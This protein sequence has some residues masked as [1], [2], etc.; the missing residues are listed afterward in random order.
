M[1]GTL[2]SIPLAQNVDENGLPL[3][4]CRLFLYLANTS[5]PVIAYKDYLLSA[6]MEHP[7]PI[8]ADALGRIP[9]FWLPTEPNS[10]YRAMLQDRYGT[11]IYDEPYMAALSTATG[12]GG[13]GEVVENPAWQTGDF[14]W[15]AV[16]GG[17]TGWV[18]ANGLTIGNALSGAVQR[19]NNDCAALF[20]TLW[21]RY[22]QEICPVL[23]GRGADAAADWGEEGAPG[24][25]IATYDM[26]AMGIRGVDGMGNS[27]TTRFNYTL[28]HHGVSTVPG[29]VVG[30]NGVILQWDHMPQH[31]HLAT[32]TNTLA[33]SPAAHQHG[34]TGGTYVSS[35]GS[36]SL[37]YDWSP[38]PLATTAATLELVGSVTVSN[39][40]AGANL[41]HD[42]VP[43]DA[44]GTW[45]IRL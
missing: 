10:F 24:K 16:S 36:G 6:G 19:A 32:V 1:T 15:Q 41:T 28:L 35:G 8:V 30:Q 44:L 13:G 21:N 43:L 18:I 2:P 20:T 29:A 22:P 40:T 33:I 38:T 17:R 26:R 12:G 14:M 9:M 23:G 4:G 45:Y 11:T 42:N 31:G 37:Q 5:T 7:H 27:A 34:Y 3:S 25:Q 39:S